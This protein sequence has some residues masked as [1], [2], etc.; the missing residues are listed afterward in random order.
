MTLQAKSVDVAHIQQTRIRR[1]VRRVARDASLGL[2]YR[3]LV[4]ERPRVLRVALGADRVLIGRRPQVL[5]LERAMGVVAIAAFDQTFIHSVV[6]GLRERRLHVR[7]ARIAELRLRN[8]QQARL[9]L[10]LVYAV[11]TDAAHAGFAVGR[12]LKVRMRPRVAAQASLVHLLRRLLADPSDLGYIAAA[13]NVGLAAPVAT[14]AGRALAAMQ[15][16]ELGVR[17]AVELLG[18]VG[19]T[20]RADIRTDKVRG[21]LGL[22]N[23]GSRRGL[24]VPTRRV[25]KPSRHNSGDE[26]DQRH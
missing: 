20:R 3:M 19:M 4:C 12:A 11:A 6:E 5:V 23:L 8:L 15:Q 18:Y 22:D 26:R 24:L 9:R 2:D 7:M 13:F 21:I 10:R 17:A 14:F 25:C 16:P 1:A